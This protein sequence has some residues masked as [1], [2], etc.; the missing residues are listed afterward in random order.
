VAAG[1]RHTQQTVPVQFDIE[2]RA[3]HDE[4]RIVAFG[5]PLADA[6]GQLAGA[7]VTKHDTAAGIRCEQVIL[8]HRQAR[9]PGAL[10]R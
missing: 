9:Q 10:A 8:P 4:P 1:V 3:G 5:I 6:P 2:E 7:V